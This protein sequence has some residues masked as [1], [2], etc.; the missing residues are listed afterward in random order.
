MPH[1]K[2]PFEKEMRLMPPFPAGGTP[3]TLSLKMQNKVSNK[4]SS[5]AGLRCWQPMVSHSPNPSTVGWVFFAVWQNRVPQAGFTHR[6]LLLVLYKRYT[7]S[8]VLVF[9]F[10]TSVVCEMVFQQIGAGGESLQLGLEDRCWS[11]ILTVSALEIVERCHRALPVPSRAPRLPI[12]SAGSSWVN[13]APMLMAGLPSYYSLLSVT[14]VG[15][16]AVPFLRLEISQSNKYG[17]AGNSHSKD[18]QVGWEEFS[19]SVSVTIWSQP[20]QWF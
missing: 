9:Y 16:I 18:F 1:L 7:N 10:G 3:A 2:F 20:W 8:R 11:F 19:I 17:K 15:I 13:K 5:G 14:Q 12:L 4:A 6:F